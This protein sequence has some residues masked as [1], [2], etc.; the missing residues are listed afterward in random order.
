V[1]LVIL[2]VGPPL[3]LLEVL[4]RVGYTR[5]TRREGRM[6]VQAL[7]GAWP[8]TAILQPHPYM[9]YVNTPNQVRLGRRQHNS[10]GYR[11]PDIAPQPPAGTLRVFA[12]G[13]STTYGWGVQDPQEAW[14]QQLQARLQR[15]LRRPVEVING[16]ILY[17]TSADMLA[18]WMF[19]DRYLGAHVVIFHVG[20]N[21]AVP[22]LFSGYNPEYT[23]FRGGWHRV[24]WGRRLGEATLLR[25]A[26]ARVAYAWWL[27]DAARTGGLFWQ[28]RPF[29]EL[30]PEEA[31]RNVRGTEPEGFRRYMDAL[32]RDV[33]AGGARPVL[34]PM[35]VAPATLFARRGL[36][37]SARF[38]ER[39][40]PAFVEGV[41][42]NR[43]VLLAL[44]ERY[45]VPL[46]ELPGEAIPLE[47]YVD[48]AHVDARGE[49]LKAAALDEKLDWEALA[50]GVSR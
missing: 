3:L 15:R 16:G 37:P 2:A 5:L 14:P 27:Q 29:E 19:R 8:T 13:E 23:H 9:L 4:C 47:S 6:A 50:A 36:A 44:A 18:H 48:H 43:R 30:T 26:A 46:L 25:S 32:L 33:S 20:G 39:W 41:Q 28:L 7:L 22:L 40:Y 38:S 31:L 10:M 49:S 11:G 35:V 45:R 21:D 24:A 17:G 34:F 1:L 12:S 42:K